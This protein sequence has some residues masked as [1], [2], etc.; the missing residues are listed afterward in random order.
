MSY[1]YLQIDLGALLNY[2][3]NSFTDDGKDDGTDYD[4]DYNTRY[5][6]ISSLR[7]GCGIYSCLRVG[8]H[9]YYYDRRS[10]WRR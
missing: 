8:R 6:D 7:R 3:T 1:L 4:T 10:W 2:G 9:D 5:R